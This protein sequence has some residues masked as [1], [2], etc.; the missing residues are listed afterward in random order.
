[1][2]LYIK[3]LLLAHLYI[4]RNAIQNNCSDESTECIWKLIALQKPNVKF[5]F[6]IPL[7]NKRA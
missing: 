3:S 4:P 7:Q 1:M 5:I 6:I 2:A